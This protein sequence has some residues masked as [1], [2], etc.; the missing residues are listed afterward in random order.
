[1]VSSLAYPNLLGT[2]MLG[3]CCTMSKKQQNQ[4]LEVACLMATVS[5]ICSVLLQYFIYP[6]LRAR[7]VVGIRTGFGLKNSRYLG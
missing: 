1:V 6:Y 4:K 7:T 5:S 3:C 2:K